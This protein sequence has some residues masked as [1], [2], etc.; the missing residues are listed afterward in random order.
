[1]LASTLDPMVTYLQKYKIPRVV[2]VAG[3]YV[4]F[5]GLIIALILY[6]IPQL[7]DDVSRF[8][9]ALPE[10]INR[11][12]TVG[13]N[14][15]LGD[16][17]TYFSG[18][19]STQVDKGQILNILKNFVVGAGS[20][21]QTTGVVFNN[22]LNIFLIIVFSFYLAV[23]EKGVPNFLKLITPKSYIDYVLGLW[24]RSQTKIANW[25]KG[26]VIVALIIAVLIY[27]PL[28]FIGMPYSMLFAVAAFIGEMIPVVGLL[29]SSIPAIVTAYFFKD[30]NFAFVVTVIYFVVMQLENYVIYP[31]VMN[32][33]LGVPP[34]IILIAVIVGAKVAGFWGILLSVPLAAAGMEFVRDVLDE[35]LPTHEIK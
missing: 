24:A 35:K 34:I 3:L 13:K 8:M 17:S 22:L 30:L 31:K 15:G 25:G 32:K 18:L 12:S 29:L 6:I 11:I 1:L 7:A 19:S 16:I 10:I 4:I 5:F 14:F 28:K 33:I 2:S 23:Q 9:S 20:V 26:Q 27:I 21:A